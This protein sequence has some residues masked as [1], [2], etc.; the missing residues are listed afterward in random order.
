MRK[1]FRSINNTLF[2]VA[3]PMIIAS[4]LGKVI[5]FPLIMLGIIITAIIIVNTVFLVK[6]ARKNNMENDIEETSDIDK[7]E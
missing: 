6:K 2:D 3:S 4:L 1:I 5:L 7:K